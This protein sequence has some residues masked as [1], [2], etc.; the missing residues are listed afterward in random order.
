MKKNVLIY[1]RQAKH[2]LREEF[3]AVA[4]SN[5]L[6]QLDKSHLIDAL[7]SHFLQASELEILQAVL[8]WGE[9]Q[10][11]RRME[12]RGENVHFYFYIT[13][14]LCIFYFLLILSKKL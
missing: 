5:V 7:Q 12:D 1:F 13:L 6:H 8:K 3:P 4:Q 9:H 14:C 2:F 11:I 10:L